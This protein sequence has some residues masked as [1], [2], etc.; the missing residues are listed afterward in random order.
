MK[1]IKK[2]LILNGKHILAPGPTGTGKTINFVDMLN[3]EM[4]EEY[5]MIPITFSAQTSA[6]QTQDGLDEKFEKRRK[7]VYG[8]P[9]G[10]KYVV[11]IDDLNMPKREV[12]FAQPPIEL[13]RQWMD[14]KGWYERGGK[15]L[16]F[17]RIEDIILVSAMG[18]PGGGRAP[19]TPRLQRHYNFLTYTD[20]DSQSITMIFSKILGRFFQSFDEEVKGSMEKLVEATKVIFN[21]V[22]QKLK[23]TPNKS[24]YTFNL[25]DI[26][27]I[28]QGVC[29]AHIKTITNKTQLLQ[30]WY[31][32]NMR[33]FADR[34]INDEDKEVLKDL[35][36]AESEKLFQVSKGNILD[37]ERL[38]F[39]DYMFGNESDGRAYQ[40]V[41]DLTKFVKRIEEY[42]LDYN[43][44]SKHPMK[45]VMFLDACDHVSRVCR[46]LRQP[47]GN[48]LLLGV[49]GSGRQSLCKL[50]NYI[51]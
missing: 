37:R 13:I 50:A 14:H 43:E 44:S 41:D 51:S 35:V 27:K 38:V 3:A 9:T 21:G 46:I 39:N 7:G 34:M 32:E 40:L 45:L 11:F 10:K 5:T 25:R 42:L 36:F 28:F 26:S 20:M 6:N 18:P 8:P 1:Y 12:Y 48:A 29:S 22:Q 30:L 15:E 24:H 31:H 17:K 16:A 49:G 2:L 47:L 23:P 19:I 4:P 33:V